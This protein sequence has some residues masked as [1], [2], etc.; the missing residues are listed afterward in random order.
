M[1]GRLAR[2]NVWL[3]RICSLVKRRNAPPPRRSSNRTCQQS[4]R[5][6]Q[7]EARRFELTIKFITHYSQE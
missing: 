2:G 3:R 6:M 4:L 7:S 5:T 1:A